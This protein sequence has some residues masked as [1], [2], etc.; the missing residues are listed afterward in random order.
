MH[1]MAWLLAAF[2][3]GA[4]AQAPAPAEPATAQ[5]AE[6]APSS[7]EPAKGDGA[8]AAAEAPATA[9]AQPAA[10]VEEAADPPQPVV[11]TRPTQGTPLHVRRGF[12]TETNIGTFFTLGGNDAYSNAQSYL[13]LGVGY[14]LLDRFELGAHIGIG[15][16]AFNCF[17]GRVDGQC[18]QTEAFTTTF[19]DVSLGY[20][21][22]V[23]DRLYL[24]PRLVGGYTRLDPAP[25]PH[26][27][28]GPNVG[29]GIG[30]EY[31][32]SMDHFSIGADVVGR[33]ILRANIPALTLMPRV[34]Y[35]F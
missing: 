1:R 33:Y 6:S 32:T 20:L 4:F 11:A 15:A 10:D 34:K 12:F 30:I 29:L 5:Q 3:L 7:A 27:W 13:Q 19:L 26:V 8:Q 14:D 35:T 18:T 9:D 17:S 16:S 22:R 31:A 25:L 21:Q 2:S 24:A 28:G 23:G